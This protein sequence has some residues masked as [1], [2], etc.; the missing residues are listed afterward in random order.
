MLGN[1]YKVLAKILA[2]RIKMA[3]THIIRPNQTGFMEGKS[4][5][6]NTFMVQEAL[7]WAEKASRI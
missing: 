2:E 6:N 7:E 5:I 1:T 4:I 3:L